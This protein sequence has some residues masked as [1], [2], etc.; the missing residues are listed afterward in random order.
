MKIL[1]LQRKSLHKINLIF[2][3]KIQIKHFKRRY[4]ND[5]KNK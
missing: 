4:E 5:T 1:Y 3:H 2:T